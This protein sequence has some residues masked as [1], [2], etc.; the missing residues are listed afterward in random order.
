MDDRRPDVIVLGAGV[1]GLTTGVCLANK[2][3]ATRLGFAVLVKFFELEARFP[4]GPDEVPAPA[5][6]YVAE[7]VRVPPEAFDAY[8][9]VGRTIEYHRA[10]IREAF[11][12][13]E[14]TRADESKLTAWLGQDVAPTETSDLALV[15]ALLARCRAERIEPPG[16]VERIVAG[17][18][19]AAS[20]AFCERTVGGQPNCPISN[21]S[22]RIV[23]KGKQTQN[24]YSNISNAL[25]GH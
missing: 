11:G 19:A 12:F 3:G 5:V 16:R 2:R 20:A 15:E 6:V 4:Q 8:A 13:R 21:Y 10:Q 25:K 24:V 23:S 14:T 22:T 7:Q 17:A 1:I 9:W 18:R